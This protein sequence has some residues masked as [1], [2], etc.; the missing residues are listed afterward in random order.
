MTLLINVKGI[1]MWNFAVMKSGF[2]DYWIGR[3]KLASDG[4]SIYAT[5]D[6]AKGKA[7]ALNDSVENQEELE[8]YQE[9]DAEEISSGMEKWIVGR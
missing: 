9:A 7:L 2:G 1:D 6:E 8:Y 4:K 5:F 3:T